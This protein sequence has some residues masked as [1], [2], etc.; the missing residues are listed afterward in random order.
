MCIVTLPCGSELRGRIIHLR[1][2]L[3]TCATQAPRVLDIALPAPLNCCFSKLPPL[4]DLPRVVSAESAKL[5]VL[6][7]VQME[8]AQLPEYKRRNLEVIDSIATPIISCM[9]TIIPQ[10]SS[11]L[12]A[13]VGWRTYFVFAVFPL[14][15]SF[16]IHFLISYLFAKYQ[17]F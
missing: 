7:N 8:L 16:A 9:A 1:S 15:F 11:R 13:T 3:A 10:L 14:V 12:D 17:K 5:E 2:D 4:H 6:E